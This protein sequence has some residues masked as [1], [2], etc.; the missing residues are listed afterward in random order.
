M[1]R[2]ARVRQVA[3][4]MVRAVQKEKYPGYLPFISTMPVV[5]R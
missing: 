5:F 2:S 3:Q 4:E 1:G